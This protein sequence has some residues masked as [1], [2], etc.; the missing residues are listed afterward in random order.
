[1]QSS[2]LK[3]LLEDKERLIRLIRVIPSRIVH[4]TRAEERS[5]LTFFGLPSTLRGQ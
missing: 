1:M 3:F 5:G 4:V 2:I